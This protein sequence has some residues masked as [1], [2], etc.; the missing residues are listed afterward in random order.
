MPSATI[1]GVNV[2]A[3]PG[4][5]IKEF[6]GGMSTKD[7]KLSAVHETITEPQT[8]NQWRCPAFTEYILMIQGEAHVEHGSSSDDGSKTTT[9]VVQAGNGVYLPKGCRVRINYPGPAEHVAICLPAFSPDIEHR[10]EGDGAT[11]APPA[12]KTD[13]TP[14]LVQSVDVVKAPALTITEYFGNVSSKDGNLSACV[15]EVKEPCSEAWQQPEFAEWVLVLSGVLHLEH[16]E[17]TTVVPA[18]SGVFLAANERVKWV[19]PEAC[20]YVPICMPAFTPDGCRREPEEG[21]AKDADPATMAELQK[22]HS[23]K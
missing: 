15:A 13:S 11:A 2:V 20:T 22:L 8:N 4:L 6:H 1:A 7:S 19:W 3:I 9:V 16:A 5:T 23:G 21:S 14:T 18:G 17:G 10:E 12:H